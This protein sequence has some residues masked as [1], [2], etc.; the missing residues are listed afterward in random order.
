MSSWNVYRQR[1]RRTVDLTSD[2]STKSVERDQQGMAIHRRVC[3]RKQVC[4]VSIHLSP[5]SV[6]SDGRAVKMS[7]DLTCQRPVKPTSWGW[8]VDDASRTIV[9]THR[10]H[11]VWPPS[12]CHLEGRG[13]QP[14]DPHWFCGISNPGWDWLYIN[15]VLVILKL[16]NLMVNTHS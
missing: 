15:I 3:T 13:G 16:T 11:I 5:Q 8:S 7:R 9:N 10:R 2:Q 1:C 6:A 12:E 4:R 14:A